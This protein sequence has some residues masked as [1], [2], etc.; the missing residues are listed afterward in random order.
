MKNKSRRREITIL[1]AAPPGKEPW[2]IGLA[3]SWIGCKK[4]KCICIGQSL[5]PGALYKGTEPYERL[6]DRIEKCQDRK[7]QILLT[8]TEGHMVQNQPIKHWT[9][10]Y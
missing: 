3:H 10:V 2:T 5:I 4:Q 7:E 6:Y 1:P 8:I 9:T